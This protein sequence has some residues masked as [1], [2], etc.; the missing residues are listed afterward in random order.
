VCF[1]NWVNTALVGDMAGEIEAPAVVA[2]YL[3]PREVAER[4]RVQPDTLKA[5]RSQG[6]GPRFVKVGG[7]V[8]YPFAWLLAFELRSHRMEIFNWSDGDAH[9]IQWATAAKSLVARALPGTSS[10]VARINQLAPVHVDIDND[11]EILISEIG[12]W[13]RATLLA[14]ANNPSGDPASDLENLTLVWK[15]GD[16]WWVTPGRWVGANTVRSPQLVDAA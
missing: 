14:V 13:T 10:A 4:L 16:S 7:C 5:W 3:T 15:V 1:D 2:V 9:E 11:Y 6:R 12:T 8:R